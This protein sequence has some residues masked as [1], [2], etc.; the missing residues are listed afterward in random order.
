MKRNCLM[1][2]P[3]VTE[4]LYSRFPNRSIQRGPITFFG[5]FSDEEIN[6]A[7]IETGRRPARKHKGPF[8]RD[9]S[10]YALVDLRV[11]HEELIETFEA[12]LNEVSLPEA[13][14]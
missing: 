4:I 12:F 14:K 13:K 1:P 9:G 8:Y 10:Y 5:P 6:Q 2:E 7:R 3:G 11:S